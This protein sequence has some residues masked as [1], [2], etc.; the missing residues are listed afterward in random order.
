[1]NNISTENKTFIPMVPVFQ[2][3]Q[4]PMPTLPAHEKMEQQAVPV[5]TSISLFT[6]QGIIDCPANMLCVNSFGMI[7]PPF[8][9]TF[10]NVNVAAPSDSCESGESGDVNVPARSRSSTPAK[11]AKP[12]PKNK[13]FRHRSKQ[14]RILE[15]HAELKEKY[16][17]LGL[18]ASDDEVLRGY[19][20][21]RVH[22]KT[23]HALNQIKNPLNAI[24]NDSSIKILKIATPFSMKNRFQKKGFIV[25]LKLADPSMV[26]AVQDIFEVYKE[27]F[28]K[29]DIALSKQQTL[30]T[31]PTVLKPLR[32][33]EES[34]KGK[35][36]SDWSAFTVM[37]PMMKKMNS[38][39]A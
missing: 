6:P 8:G 12:E 36:F 15:V 37:P 2:L 17:K 18:Y 13:K 38:L 32:V 33:E 25:Y 24:E 39:G 27:H 31:I 35:D 29:C 26:P 11:E 19:D 30:S 22:V 21:V 23:Y 34:L 16:T 28:A 14:E 5:G 1:M 3:P 7:V 4:L 10:V 9:F 20:T